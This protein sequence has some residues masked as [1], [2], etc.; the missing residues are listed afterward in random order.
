M[1]QPTEPGKSDKQKG[2][3]IVLLV[4]LA[5]TTW[6]IVVPTII[7]ALVGLKGDLTWHTAPWLTLVGTVIGF[8]LAA[9]LIRRQLKEL[10]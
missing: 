4:T 5:D 7:L 1:P 10:S 3:T 2:Q 8:A 9:L 6:R